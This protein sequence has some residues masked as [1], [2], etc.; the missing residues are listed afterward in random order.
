MVLFFFFKDYDSYSLSY[1]AQNDLE[2]L[3]LLPPGTDTHFFVCDNESMIKFFSKYIQFF[4][5]YS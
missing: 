3:I 1:V 2:L 4:A 5:S